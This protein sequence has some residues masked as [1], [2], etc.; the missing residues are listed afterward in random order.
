[1]EN[2]PRIYFYTHIVLKITFALSFFSSILSFKFN[3]KH[4]LDL[5][6]LSHQ[7][8]YVLVSAL[9]FAGITSDPRLC[10]YQ[11]II[12]LNALLGSMVIIIFL[13][14]NIIYLCFKVNKDDTVTSIPMKAIYIQV[15][16]TL[17]FVLATTIST[18]VNPTISHTNLF[19]FSASGSDLETL[20]TT[21]LYLTFATCIAAIILVESIPYWK[22]IKLT[23][24]HVDYK[25]LDVYSYYL[26]IFVI[27]WGIQGLSSPASEKGTLW[28]IYVIRVRIY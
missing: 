26:V 21:I 22:Y 6:L 24:D 14:L 13:S 10:L 16:I 12:L 1:M 4:P 15:L 9:G 11:G 27:I 8:F 17:T 19:C 7:A 23:H 20:F 2:Q 25:V 5:L 3:V 18:F 28:W